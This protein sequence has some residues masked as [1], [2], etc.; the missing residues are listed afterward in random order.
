MLPSIILAGLYH[1]DYF[2]N[3]SEIHDLTEEIMQKTNAI[4]QKLY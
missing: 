2:K 1:K 4:T 3:V